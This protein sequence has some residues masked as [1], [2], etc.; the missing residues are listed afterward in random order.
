MG[1]KRN[2]LVFSLKFVVSFALIAYILIYRTSIKDILEALSGASLFW[3]LISFSLHALG[4]L[5]SAY[6]WQILIRAQ[7]D[8]VPL[9]F[10]AK[11]YLVSSFF[12]NFLPTRIGGDVIRIWDGSRYS[13]SLVKSSAVIVVERLTGIIVLFVFALIASLI[14]LEMA[15]QIPVIWVSLLVGILGLLLIALFFTPVSKKLLE[16]IPDKGIFQKIKPKV[17]TFRDTAL[18]YRDKKAHFFKAMFWALL[19]QINVILHY[20]LIGKALHLE[21]QLIDYFIFIPIIHLILI[22]PITISGFGLREGAYIEIFRF[23]GISASAAVSFSFID[24][25]FQLVVGLVG[26]VIYITR[27]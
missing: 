19:L 3:I 9:G 17:F 8:S 5:I 12:N 13:R 22:I 2:F 14:R 16:R 26:A 4:L 21:I 27:K 7:G 15:Q 6:R 24:V 20:F 1:K 23:Y 18:I 11:S 10:L 25:I